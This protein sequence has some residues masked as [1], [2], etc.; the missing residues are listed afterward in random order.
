MYISSFSTNKVAKVVVLVVS[1]MG[2]L[3]L[4]SCNQD[5]SMGV[6]EKLEENKHP[7]PFNVNLKSNWDNSKKTDSRGTPYNYMGTMFSVFG[8]YYS[9]GDVALQ[10]MNYMW[11]VESGEYE[12]G[13]QTTVAFSDPPISKE[14]SFYAYCPYQPE[15]I[16]EKYIWVNNNDTL[17]VGPPFFRFT[18]PKEVANQ[19]DLMI[20][21]TKMTSNQIISKT[22]I[23][24]QFSHLLTAVRFTIDETVPK[25]FIREISI[26]SVS[27]GG[28]FYFED[29]T[30]DWRSLNDTLQAYTLVRDISLDGKTKVNLSDEEVFMMMPQLLG[31]KAQVRIKYDNGQVFDLKTSLAG[32]LWE[33]GKIVTYNIKINSL[34]YLTLTSTIEPWG[35]GDTFNWNSSY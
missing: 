12:D 31:D 4:S 1:I 18:I 7:I 3:L 35:V 2:N 33:K 26:D 34:N 8:G 27:K 29:G 19:V 21:E 10:T 28:T 25:G 9:T 15:D 20:A 23:P 32:R 5:G 24:L 30:N 6:P 13:W 22:P 11:D 14:M 17:K 16:E